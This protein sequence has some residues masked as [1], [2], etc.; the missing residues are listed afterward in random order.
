MD[1][2]E[3]LTALTGLSFPL[4]RCP[5]TERIVL[6]SRIFGWTKRVNET[7][8]MIR[9]R[10]GVN[11]SERFSSQRICYDSQSEKLQIKSTLNMFMILLYGFYQH[12]HIENSSF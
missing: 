5:I 6:L 4:K 11:Q 8:W 1:M 2:E 9:S 10:I 3:A 7:N 12:T